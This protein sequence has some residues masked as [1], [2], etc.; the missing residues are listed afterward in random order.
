MKQSFESCLITT[1]DRI[2]ESAEVLF[3]NHG[4]EGTSLRD[5]TERAGVNVAA[6]NYHF[7]SKE[8]LL[9]ELLDRVIKPINAERLELLSAVSRD[10]HP[11]IS[12][13]LTA[14]LLP[15]VNGLER[16]RI[17]DPA[18]PRFVSRMYSESS[19]LMGQVIGEQFSE[20]SRRFG[21]AFNDALPDLDADEI[22]FRL[23]CVVGIV[24]YMFAGVQTPAMV[25]I[26]G[27]DAGTTLARLLD[28]SK[29]IMLAPAEVV[30]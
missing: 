2:I 12:E 19:P 14:F 5:I 24:V 9:T 26:A 18:L 10:G 16:L 23:T 28:V 4:Y 3:A 13:I 7:G 20:V 29:A 17:R 27:K 6:V 15:D 1:R 22:A 8:L 30:A 21:K 25:P 11:T